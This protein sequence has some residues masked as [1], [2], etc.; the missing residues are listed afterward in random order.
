MKSVKRLHQ[1][2]EIRKK[3]L[4]ESK[5]KYLSEIKNRSAV[6][7]IE[8]IIEEESNNEEENSPIIKKFNFQILIL[9]KKKQKK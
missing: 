9:L 3:T 6:S 4:N 5:L 8:K 1:E 7:L 2:N